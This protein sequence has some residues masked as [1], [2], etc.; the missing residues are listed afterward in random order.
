MEN[1]KTAVDESITE[2]DVI[3][4]PSCGIGSRIAYGVYGVRDK[5]PSA[6]E[7]LRNTTGISLST[8]APGRLGATTG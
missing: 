5:R 7:S 8:S 3:C 2:S 6:S 1:Q 4:G